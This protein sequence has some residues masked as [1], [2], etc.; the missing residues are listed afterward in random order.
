MGLFSTIN[1][2]ATGMSVER[3]RTDVIADNI[4]NA[5][6]TRTQE[7]GAYRRKRVIVAPMDAKPIFRN[8]FV[9]ADL[10]NG[11]GRGVRVKEIVKD[12]EPGKLI[13]DPSHPDAAESG[14]RAGYV[15]YPN[16]NIVNEMT[17]L[18]SA[19]RAY[20]AHSSVIQGAKEMFSSALEIAR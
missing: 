14:E 10:D 19:S 16:V 1:I 7:G 9:P 18:I 17:D 6:T 20:E 4:A 13:Y 3:L 12:T 15:E 11:P 2:A 5:T 8:P